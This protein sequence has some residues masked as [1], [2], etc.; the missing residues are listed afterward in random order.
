MHQDVH[1]QVRKCYIGVS[2]LFELV[3]TN[4]KDHRVPLLLASVMLNLLVKEM[5]VQ[6]QFFTLL[7]D[8]LLFAF[9]SG[10]SLCV[11]SHHVLEENI[12]NNMSTHPFPDSSQLLF[13]EH[14]PE[15]ATGTL[16]IDPFYRI[17]EF[18][19]SDE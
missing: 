13:S 18:H 9:D 10:R 17:Y 6:P 1:F 14:P 7:K 8:T 16:T 11:L 15:E 4:E 19:T 3:S 12:H 5:K 2:Y